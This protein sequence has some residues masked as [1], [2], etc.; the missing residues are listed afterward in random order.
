MPNNLSPDIGPTKN[1]DV[2]TVEEVAAQLRVHKLTVYRA[3][4]SGKLQ[5]QRVGKLIRINGAALAD[6]TGEQQ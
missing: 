6:F 4:K 3:I 2:F 5:A 1:A